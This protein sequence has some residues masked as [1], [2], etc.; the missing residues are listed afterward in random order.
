[1]QQMTL[2][3][4]I[5]D[6]DFFNQDDPNKEC[7]EIGQ[8]LSKEVLYSQRMSQVLNEFEPNASSE[9][10][11]AARAQH[12]GRWLSA[13]SDYPQG[14]AGYLNWRKDLGKKHAQ[15]CQEILVKHQVE[16]AQ[17]ERVAQLLRKEKLKKDPEVQC[18]EDVIC[19]VFVKYYLSDFA[20]KHEKDKLL[21]IIAKTW[22]KM[23]D[24]GHAAILEL[25]LA[26]E[27]KS[28][29]LEALA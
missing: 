14:K 22:N 10:Q 25:E 28:V 16:L 13:R 12:M 18:L 19:I 6:I 5:S 7:N 29:L 23:S 11:I 27:L 9:L 17:Q 3:R 4:V 8:W 26:P 2:E 1:M 15:L 20:A 21:S 24:K